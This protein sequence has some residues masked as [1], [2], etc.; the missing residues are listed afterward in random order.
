MKNISDW[1]KIYPPFILNFGFPEKLE[2]KKQS[3]K[4]EAIKGPATN[5]YNKYQTY[6]DSSQKQKYNVS[7][8]LARQMKLNIEEN[9]LNT[10]IASNK[11]YTPNE[12]YRYNGAYEPIFIDIPIFNNVYLYLS[13]TT[14]KYWDSNYKFD[15]TFENFGMIEE[16]VFSKV[17]PIESP[18]KL[19]NTEK[20]LSL[21]PIVD[22]YGYEY[23]NRFIFNSSWD[24]DFYILT[25]SEQ[26]INKQVFSNLSSIEY[27][28]DQ[29]KPKA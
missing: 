18:L 26:N 7:E 19:K 24:K 10:V 17:N 2:T 4:K 12:I 23:G 11:V 8:P 5:I 28:I 25:N 15:T 20:D 16:L 13:S 1:G 29:I 6:Y 3:Y 27:I 9:N 21:Y 14:V 22:E